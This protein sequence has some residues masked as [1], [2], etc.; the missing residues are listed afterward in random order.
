[1]SDVIH[2]VIHGKTI[3]LAENPGIADGQP[4][5]VA[6]RALP[7]AR[8]GARNSCIGWCPCGPSGNGCPS[9][10]KYIEI[11]RRPGSARLRNELLLDTKYARAHPQNSIAEASN[12][13][14]STQVRR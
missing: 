14:P 7:A 4:V 10:K 3:V 2:G 9:R 11:A 5:E 8:N 12:T 13:G 1:M 6:V